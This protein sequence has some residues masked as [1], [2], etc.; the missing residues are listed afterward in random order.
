MTAEETHDTIKTLHDI[1]R[2]IRDFASMM[3]ASNDLLLALLH[4]GANVTDI[5]DVV[6]SEQALLGGYLARIAAV[7]DTL[8][9]LTNAPEEKP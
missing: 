6:R 9:I 5:I 4:A 3:R 7:A 8:R 1:S 2:M